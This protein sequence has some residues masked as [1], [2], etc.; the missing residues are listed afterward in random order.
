MKDIAPTI[1]PPGKR[2]GWYLIIDEFFFLTFIANREEYI[3]QG[4]KLQIFQR[5][6][7]NPLTL[8]SSCNT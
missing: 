8:P 4:S 2:I 3:L 1:W 7:I 5:S 6:T